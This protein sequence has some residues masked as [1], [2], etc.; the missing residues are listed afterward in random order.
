MVDDQELQ[1]ADSLDAMFSGGDVSQMYFRVPCQNSS[2]L[3][4]G[5]PPMTNDTNNVTI[6]LSAGDNATGPGGAEGDNQT[7]G[8]TDI[9]GALGIEVMA[10]IGIVALLAIAAAVVLMRRR[11]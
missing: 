10:G 2:N 7:G 6:V 8:S 1:Q 9:T 11:R 4:I 3:V 5:L